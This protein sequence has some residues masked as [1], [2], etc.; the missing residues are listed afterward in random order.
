MR[1]LEK[2]KMGL[3]Y[4][5]QYVKT[6]TDIVTKLTSGKSCIILNPEFAGSPI[7]KEFLLS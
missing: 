5:F 3:S 2:R 7:L 1:F 4:F 6:S